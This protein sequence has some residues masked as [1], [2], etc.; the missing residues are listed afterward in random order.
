MEQ[1]MNTM[2]T[3]HLLGNIEKKTIELFVVSL[4]VGF[5]YHLAKIFL[6]TLY[7]IYTLL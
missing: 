7:E 4:K 2:E 1:I 5:L 3:M 6:Y